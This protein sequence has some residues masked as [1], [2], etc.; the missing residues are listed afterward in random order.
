MKTLEESIATAMDLNKDVAIVPHL[1]Y[2][3]QD[4]WEM[5]TPSEA[6]INL[7]IKHYKNYSKCNVLDLGCGKGAVSV[8]LA[9]ALKCNCHGID[10][11]PEFIEVS[12]AKAEEH[13]VAKLCQFEV[14][15]I[16]E[17]I[18][19]LDKFDVIVLG[20]IGQVFDNYYKTLITLSKHLKTNGIIIIADAY[21]EDSNTFQH[22]EILS[23]QDILK[24][25]SLAKMELIDEVESKQSNSS[26]EFEN[27]EKRCKELM[28][29]HTKK[30]SIFENYIQSQAEEYDILEN[31]VIGSI[32]VF[33]RERVIVERNLPKLQVKYCL[34]RISKT[35]I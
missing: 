7:I 17:K 18:E 31:K 1:P 13:D 32:M 35:F 30:A 2:I 10:G 25:V 27:L 29:K 28:R 23:R 12:K 33:K 9:A 14:G 4:F 15:D 34:Q 3:L 26:E 16:R 20:A 24:Q 22:P 21:T 11:I 19:E 8:R 6:I 5:G